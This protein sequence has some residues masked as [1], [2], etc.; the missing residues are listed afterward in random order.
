MKY[1]TLEA[2]Q[3]TDGTYAQALFVHDTYDNAIAKYHEFMHYQM[4]V[5][6]TQ[7]ALCMVISEQGVVSVTER[8]DKPVTTESEE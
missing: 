3:S 5:G 6:T 7:M 8:W 2:T 4:I 1:Y